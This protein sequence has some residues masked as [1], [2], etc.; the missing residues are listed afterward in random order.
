MKNAILSLGALIAL[1]AVSCTMEESFPDQQ[2]IG[3]ELTITATREGDETMTRTYRDNADGSIWWVPGD[4]ISL[5]YGSGTDGGSKFT[6]VNTTDTTK[7]T[8]FTGVITAITGGGEIPDDQT[9]FWGLYPYQEDASCDGTSVTMTLPKKQTAVPGSFATNTFPSLGRSQGLTMGFYNICG[10][11]KFS[12]TK[13]GIKRVTLKSGNGELITG[14]AEV[15]F[16]NGIPAAEI[17]DGSDE[18]VLE[19]PAGEYFE[20]GQYYYIVIFP[21]TFSNGFSIKLENYTEEATVEKTGVLTAKRSNFGRISNIDAGATYSQKTGIIPIDDPNFQHVEMALDTAYLKV[22]YMIFGNQ[23]AGADHSWMLFGLGLDTF[24]PTSAA[25]HFSNWTTLTPESGYASFY[26]EHMYILSNLANKVV[27]WIDEHPEMGYTN[28]TVKNNLRAEAVFLRAWAFRVITGMFGQVVYSE[29]AMQSDSFDQ[30]M[31]TREEAW[32]KIAADFEYAE[33]NLPFSPRALGSVTKAAAAH[34]LSEIHLSLGEFAEAEAAASRVI[35]GQDGD[36][37]L[38]TS[39]FGNRKDQTVDRYG[40]S[41]S[42]PKGAYWDLFRTSGMTQA[43]T[44]APES[45][46]NAPDNKEAIWVAQIDYQ[47]GDSWWRM[48]RPVLESTWAPWIPLG[49]KNGTRMGS[50]GMV[51]FVFTAD[52]VCFPEGVNPAGAGTPGANIPEAQGRKLAYNLSTRL[53]SLACRTQGNNASTGQG[54]LASEYVVRPA[55]DILGSYW[56]DPNDFRGSEV[57]VQRDYYTPS[58]KKWSEVKKEVKARVDAGLYTVTASDTV[59]ITP[60]YWK[61]SDDRHI[62]DNNNCYYDTDW[63][64]IRIAETYLLRAEARLAQG[65]K[66]GAAEDINVLRN[67]AGAKP[68]TAGDIDIDYIL[69]ERVRELFGEEQRWVTLSRLSC[70]PNATY[71]LDKYPTQDATT[72]NTLYE[73]TRKYGFGYEHDDHGREAYT[74]ALGNTRHRPNIQPHNYVLPIPIQIIQSN[75]GIYFEQNYG[76]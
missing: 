63:Y 38:M 66:S 23:R 13:E 19:A 51:Y 54:L 11:V 10:G 37:H 74:D 68:A 56:D 73:R 45:N 32:E 47:S 67:R 1:A 33:E 42:A 29:H 35:N 44:F 75:N 34:Y 15:R 76:Y 14:K 41:L 3:K 5:F 61:F 7:V 27:D 46:P 22:Q 59:N 50:D 30:A 17:I 62:I 36:Y 39:R 71:V 69:D 9:Y 60:R 16:E 64:M 21:T 53:D 2:N 20:V 72:S 6:S 25:S 8:N 65:N 43:G 70:N 4:A 12:V 48:H 18:V 57:M 26:S 49:G 40:N 24:A 52:A 58:G 31:I 28:E 55:G